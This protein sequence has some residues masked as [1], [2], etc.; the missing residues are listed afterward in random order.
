MEIEIRNLRGC[1]FERVFRG[2]ERAFGDYEIRF[3]KEEVRGMLTRRGFDPELSAGAFDAE[4]EIV[5]FVFNGVG[6]FNDRLTAYDTG[7]GTAPDYR[8]EGLAG[9]VFDHALGLLRGA[10]VEQYLLEVLQN[11]EKAIRLYEGAGFEISREFDCFRSSIA[12]VELA[13]SQGGAAFEVRRIGVGEVRA[14]SDFCDFNPSWQNSV[15]SIERGI[16]GLTCLGAF[17]DGAMVGYCVFDPATGDL[18]QIAVSPAMRRKGVGSL[19]LREALG[20]MKTPFMK[21]LNVETGTDSLTA[22]LKHRNI[23]PAT[24]QYEMLRRL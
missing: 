16:A 12:E 19:L 6:M 20:A 1:G 22:F 17:A 5:G 15:Q 13:T 11:N 21:V 7:T 3:D 2:F 14:A 18:T 24:S 10:G 8:G 23:K 9:R 4:G